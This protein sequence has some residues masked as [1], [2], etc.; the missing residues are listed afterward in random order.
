MSRKKMTRNITIYKIY[1]V[2]RDPWFWSTILISSLMK[3][4]HMRLSEI[5]FMES[6]VMLGY[7]FFE[8]P[9]GAFADYIG[10]KVAVVFGCIFLLLGMTSFAFMN[11]SKGAWISNI[12]FMIGI[13]LCSGADRA[14]L[15]DTL[16]TLD[17][18]DEIKKIQGKSQSIGLL[19]VAFTSLISG[20]LAEISLRLPLFLCIPNM[21]LCLIFTFFFTEPDTMKRNR[22]NINGFGDFIKNTIKAMRSIW[23]IM[24]TSIL[25]VK[26][27]KK[28]KWII[29]FFTLISVS[30]KLWF[31][32]YNPYFEIVNLDYKYYGYAFFTLNIV[33]CFFSYYSEK[34]S[35]IMGEKN[36]LNILYLFIGVPILF[37]GTVVS[38]M[39]VSII[40][41]QNVVRGLSSPI[42]L[43]MIDKRLTPERKATIQS[44]SSAVRGLVEF[45]ALAVFGVM[46]GIFNLEISL[47]LLGASV[48][49]LGIFYI[50]K[51]KSIF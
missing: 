42:Y 51:Y 28:L 9:S 26:N 48:I 29:S 15:S 35:T 4:A 47:Q 37:M 7:V 11:S 34:I 36:T 39:S 20:F 45:V 17:K 46:L 1:V 24:I 49:V 43:G 41:L 44:I 16:V 13:S 2:T 27:N 31:F 5:Y 10:R 6:V 22:S 30:S 12:I 8:I 3:L 18:S 40:V 21:L 50:V 25:H 19:V 32:S 33:A 23:R 14:L 38:K